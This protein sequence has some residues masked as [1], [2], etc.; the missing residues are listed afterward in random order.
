MPIDDALIDTKVTALRD[1]IR[2][3]NEQSLSLEEIESRLRQVRTVKSPPIVSGDPP[4]MEVPRDHQTGERF[5]TG[6]RQS[7]YDKAIIDADAVLV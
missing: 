3:L 6:R 2:T 7:I 5:T 1:K 4:I